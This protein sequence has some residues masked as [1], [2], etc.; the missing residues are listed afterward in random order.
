MA[1]RWDLVMWAKHASEM[2]YGMTSEMKS[3][4]D[5]QNIASAIQMYGSIFLFELAP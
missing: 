2:P 4:Y 1:R 3:K 5:N